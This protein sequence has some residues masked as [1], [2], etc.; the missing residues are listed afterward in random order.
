MASPKQNQRRAG[1][2]AKTVPKTLT[3]RGVAR[4]KNVS[5]PIATRPEEPEVA[6]G[7]VERVLTKSRVEKL[8]VEAGV[9]DLA[10]AKVLRLEDLGADRLAP[11]SLVELTGLFKLFLQKNNLVSLPKRVF[12]VDTP[13]MLTFLD[14]SNNKLDNECIERI[15]RWKL[16]KLVT[17]KL[18]GN[19]L[20][21]FSSAAL[22]HMKQL[23]AL[24]LNDNQIESIE[25]PEALPAVNT[26]IVSG[27]KLKKLDSR[28]Q[29][30]NLPGLK[31][32]SASKN[33]LGSLPDIRRCPL[34]AE[35]RLSHNSITSL[36]PTILQDCNKLAVLDVSNNHI[37]KPKQ[38]EVLKQ[39]SAS[40]IHV[41]IARNPIVAKLLGVKE[42]SSD[43]NF[44]AEEKEKLVRV[45]VKQFFKDASRLKTCDGVLLDKLGLAPQ[46]VAITETKD[47]SK[48]SA[49][50]SGSNQRGKVNVS[51]A[52]EEAPPKSKAASTPLTPEREP[53]VQ[54]VDPARSGV[55]EVIVEKVSRHKRSKPES[56]E[57]EE[58]KLKKKSKKEK[59]NKTVDESVD[60]DGIS[61]S[62][63]T[64]RT[65]ST[66]R[67]VDA[68]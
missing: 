68:W 5:K 58:K 40:L 63:P 59:K 44:S 4:E 56:D 34:L 43:D 65:W 62:K 49:P 13:S 29:L 67:K 53:S 37:T 26:L 35:L 3:K 57:S 38:I 19:N 14:L 55:A 45:V 20:T 48:K 10:K 39:L 42:S 61:L 18:A 6:S 15:G 16:E 25:F 8:M 51:N 1:P 27:N 17:L 64:T 36:D 60:A 47:S 9:S 7:A 28:T 24:V 66:Q 22:A 54:T 11:K 50:T 33:D 2:A 12:S 52:A 46:P 31:K 30:E 32:L 21:H 41:S 23:A